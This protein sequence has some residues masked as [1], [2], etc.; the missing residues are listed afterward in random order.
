MSLT[1]TIGLAYVL[2]VGGDL[3][4]PVIGAI[5]TIVG[6]AAYGKHPRNI[7]PI[8]IGCVFGLACEAL[9][10]DGSFGTARGLV[11]DDTGA[12]CRALRM[13]LGHRGRFPAFV[14]RAQRR[15]G[16]RRAEPVQ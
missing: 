7:V 13:A 5:F 14:R 4:G 12:D 15:I 2:M 8:M 11:R 9:E 16:A 3:N 6:F 1:G 10:R